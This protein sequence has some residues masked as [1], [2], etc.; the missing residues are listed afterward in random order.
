[1][2]RLSAPTRSRLYAYSLLEKCLNISFFPFVI[3][4]APINPYE[5]RRLSPENVQL[6]TA[7]VVEPLF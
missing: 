6:Y 7:T 1:M 4:L 3:L 5:L 2:A